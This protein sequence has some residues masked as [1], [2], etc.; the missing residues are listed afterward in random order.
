MKFFGL[1]GKN[2][3]TQTQS[4]MG[5][6]SFGRFN[7]QED[8]EKPSPATAVFIPK[9]FDDVQAIIDTLK[10]NKTV[11]VH[12]SGLKTESTVRVLDILSGAVYALNGG[13]Y[14]LPGSKNSF[15]FSPNTIELHR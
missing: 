9:S 12:L 7:P 1:F 8:S 4:Y 13:V 14:E 6:D 3:E 2:A 10:Q 15:L 11:I 5:S